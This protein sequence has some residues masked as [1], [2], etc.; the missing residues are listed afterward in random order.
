MDSFPRRKVWFPSRKVSDEALAGMEKKPR[1]FREPG[2]KPPQAK[3]VAPGNSV[4]TTVASEPRSRKTA[5][6]RASA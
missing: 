1:S 2:A 6:A 4:P 5:L 3:A